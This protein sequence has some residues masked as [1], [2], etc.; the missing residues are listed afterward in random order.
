MFPDKGGMTRLLASIVLAMAGTLALTGSVNPQGEFA[1]MEPD[2]QP[3]GTSGLNAQQKE[4]VNLAMGQFDAQGLELPEIDFVFHDDLWPC[5]GHKGMFHKSTRTLE[6]C[7]MD[8]HTMLHELAHAWANENLS[9]RVRED[10][11]LSRDLDSWNDHDDAWDRRGTEH[12]AET[13]A[14]ALAEDPRH[15]R[16]L[17]T[18]PDGS[19]ETTHRILSIGVDVDTLLGNFKDITGMDPVFRHASEWAVDE[20][21][22]TV[23]S[24]ELARLGS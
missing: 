1:H 24:P 5:H 6:M 20:G 10:F 12:V 22:P 14:W 7:S 21:A 2:D 17:E 15:V 23:I 11:M 3:S 18:L 19:K 9:E 4:L 16:W 13:I 8:P